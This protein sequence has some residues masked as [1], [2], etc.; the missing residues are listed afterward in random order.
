M[1]QPGPVPWEVPNAGA[2][3]VALLLGGVV[4]HVLVGRACLKRLLES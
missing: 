2:A 1:S 3:L 4:G